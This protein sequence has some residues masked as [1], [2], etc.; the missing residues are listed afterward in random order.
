VFTKKEKEVRKFDN[1][2]QKS[3]L[4]IDKIKDNKV[5]MLQQI[6]QHN[7]THGKIKGQVT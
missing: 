6:M 5:M 2:K 4:T 1:S 3:T 7:F